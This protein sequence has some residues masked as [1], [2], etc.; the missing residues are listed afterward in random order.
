MKSSS[1]V[2]LKIGVISM[3]LDSIIDR[4]APGKARSVHAHLHRFFKWAVGREII[5]V[6]PMDGLE[7]PVAAN[8]RDRVLSDDELARECGTPPTMVLS[9]TSLSC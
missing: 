2:K 3:L 6:S 7:C 5:P 9:V 1:E 8:R 4:G